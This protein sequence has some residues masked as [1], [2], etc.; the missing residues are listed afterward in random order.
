MATISSSDLQ[1]YCVSLCR[2]TATQTWTRP[3]VE[4]ALQAIEDFMVLPAT[5]TS[6]GGAIETA[7][8][9]VFTAAQKLT[10]FGIWCELAA[11][12]LG[13]S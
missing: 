10:L 3:Q 4:A 8:P 11:S 13:V 2:N 5:K 9:T 7:A 6:I 1:A 12:R